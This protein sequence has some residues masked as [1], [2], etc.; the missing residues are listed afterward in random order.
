MAELHTS[1]SE[2]LKSEDD[3]AKTRARAAPART[4]QQIDETVRRLKAATEIGDRAGFDVIV[5][6]VRGFAVADAVAV[7]HAY[8]GGGKA[9]ASKAKALQAIEERWLERVRARSKNMIAE[10]TRI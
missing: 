8:K 9:P 4:A 2:P 10:R 3:M 5:V 1:A 7:A 6:D